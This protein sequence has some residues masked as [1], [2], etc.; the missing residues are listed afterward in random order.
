MPT[1]DARRDDINTLRG[2]QTKLVPLYPGGA[3]WA[4]SLPR[5]KEPNLSG[6][7]K[8]THAYGGVFHVLR[9]KGWLDRLTLSYNTSNS[10]AA[11]NFRTAIDGSALR[12]TSGTRKDFGIRTELFGEKITLSA[13]RFEAEV[14]NVYSIAGIGLI[15]TN[16]SALYDAIGDPQKANLGAASGSDTSDYL[17]GL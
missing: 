4:Q 17:E 3:N 8:D 1:L 15:A 11:N 13:T 10:F 9:K 16:V 12:L 14:L 5:I 7:E 6:Q 2:D